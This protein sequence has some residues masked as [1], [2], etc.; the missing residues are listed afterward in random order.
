MFE[1]ILAF[2]LS[3]GLPGLFLASLI[4]STIFI[5]FS[6]EVT[7]PL[8]SASGLSKPSIWFFTTLGSYFGTV[9]NYYVGVTGVKLTGKYLKPE[10]LEKAKKLMNK[11]GWAG[12][13]IALILPLPLPV[14]PITVL[15][16]MAKMNFKEFTIVVL[17][18]KA[19]KAALVLGLISLFL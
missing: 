2:T 5:P 14:D 12:L 18:G 10:N 19:V 16:G 6:I 3:I 15:C 9:I 4:G 1:S 8:F 13:F 11:Y 17:S 7:F